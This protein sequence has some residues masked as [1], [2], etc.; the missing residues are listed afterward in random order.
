AAGLGVQRI[1]RA[2]KARLDAGGP[3]YW[4]LLRSGIGILPARHRDPAGSAQR[5][6]DLDRAGHALPDRDPAR[7]DVCVFV[8]FRTR[9]AG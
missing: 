9:C 4:R 8:R 5:R 1:P 3:R 2:A 7:M 6:G